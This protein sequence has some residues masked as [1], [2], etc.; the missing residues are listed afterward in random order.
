[1]SILHEGDDSS[2]SI[3]RTRE[4]AD[5]FERRHLSKGKRDGKETVQTMIAREG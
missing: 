2:D 5:G 4:H 3:G 1:M